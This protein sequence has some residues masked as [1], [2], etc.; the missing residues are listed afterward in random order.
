MAEPY[1]VDR[2]SRSK[3]VRRSRDPARQS[4]TA[5]GTLVLVNLANCAVTFGR[6]GQRFLSLCQ[7]FLS[8][9]DLLFVRG[10][11]A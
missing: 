1:M 5:P 6:L 9:S 2:D 11:F 3:R 8:F 10:I 7:S 4:G